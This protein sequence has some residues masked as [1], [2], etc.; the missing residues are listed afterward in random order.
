ME[1]HHDQVLLHRAVTFV[2]VVLL[3]ALDAF[4][5]GGGQDRVFV[6]SYLN[7]T[8]PVRGLISLV[9]SWALCSTLVWFVGAF[10]GCCCAGRRV[11]VGG[12]GGVGGVGARRVA[13]AVRAAPAADRAGGRASVWSTR[14]EFERAALADVAARWRSTGH[15]WFDTSCCRREWMEEINRTFAS[16]CEF[17]PDAA[18]RMIYQ[19]Q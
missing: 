7:L 15:P 8:N 9:L 3:G 2:L 13:R 12:G 14:E 18:A 1:M 11:A 10:C 4:S 6:L 16:G 17:N 5:G 19:Q